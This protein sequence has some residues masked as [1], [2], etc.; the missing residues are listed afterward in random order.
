MAVFTG[1][2]YKSC[3]SGNTYIIMDVYVVMYALRKKLYIAA[4]FKL[5][6]YTY[7]YI[8]KSIVKNIRSIL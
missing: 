7:Y 8:Y 6:R 2:A 5:F 4:L 3:D 1:M